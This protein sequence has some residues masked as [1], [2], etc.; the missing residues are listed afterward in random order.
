MIALIS[1]PLHPS[2]MWPKQL[3]EHS[4]LMKGQMQEPQVGPKIRVDVK[5]VS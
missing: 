4:K 1:L 5:V 3:G 2:A